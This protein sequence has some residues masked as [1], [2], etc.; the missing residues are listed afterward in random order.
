MKEIT[1]T[2]CYNNIPKNTKK[3]KEKDNKRT[4]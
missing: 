4:A 1:R 3:K 2:D